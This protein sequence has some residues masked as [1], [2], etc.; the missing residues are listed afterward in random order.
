ME[1]ANAMLL[2]K[3][4]LVTLWY[5]SHWKATHLTRLRF[6]LGWGKTAIR[7]TDAALENEQALKTRGAS[8]RWRAAGF[9]RWIW[10]MRCVVGCALSSPKERN[11]LASAPK[12]NAKKGQG[13][14]PEFAIKRS[15]AADRTPKVIVQAD[16]LVI[17]DVEAFSARHAELVSCDLALLAS[18]M[19]P[20]ATV[21][22]HPPL[23]PDFC[24]PAWG[25]KRQLLASDQRLGSS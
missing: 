23:A 19:N 18:R 11:W 5:S 25:R 10:E 22:L 8:Y 17:A 16:G 9:A 15:N 7:S 12:G 14:M 13:N 4:P 20:A 21:V 2:M 6:E 24:R 3:G 1:A